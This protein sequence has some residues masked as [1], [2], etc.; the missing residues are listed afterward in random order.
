V[1]PGCIFGWTGTLTTTGTLRITGY[2]PSVNPNTASGPGATTCDL[3]LLPSSTCTTNGGN[4]SN[5][6]VGTNIAMFD[7]ALALGSPG[8]QLL[9][10][11][12]FTLSD[13]SSRVIQNQV[14]ATVVPEPG[15][16]GLLGIG[17]IVLGLARRR[18]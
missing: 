2:D 3:S 17:I 4:A 11:G 5:G 7:I 16:A 18:A 13:F 6:E 10:T 15:T 1:G 9:Y 14:L 8:D 12:D